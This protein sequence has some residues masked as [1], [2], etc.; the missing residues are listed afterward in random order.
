MPTGYLAS[1]A[2]DAGISVR[3]V[4]FFTGVAMLLPVGAWFWALRLWR[5]VE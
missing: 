4:A 3:T 1:V 2:I 5:E